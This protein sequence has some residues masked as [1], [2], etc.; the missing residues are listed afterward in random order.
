M[1]TLVQFPG[2]GLSFQINRIAF[3]IGSLNVYWYGVILATGLF[4]GVMFAFRHCTEFGIESDR[5][6]D[7]ILVG[8]VMAIVCARAYY[9]LMSPYEYDNIWQMLDVRRGGIAIYGAIAGAF[10]FGGLACKWR[11]IPLLPMFDLV[12][13]GFLI[14]QG[15]GR[16]GNFVNQEAFGYNTTLPWGMYSQA[17]HDYLQ[18]NVVTLPAGMTADPSL[19]VYPTFLYESIW[20]LAGFVLLYFYFK[21][22]KFHGDLALRYA[23]W[24]G[25]GRFWI[26]GL[27]TDS[28]LLV[29][30]LNLRASQLVAAV[31]VAA[32]LVLLVVLTR[33]AKQKQPLMVDLAI[34]SEALKAMQAPDGPIGVILSDKVSKLPASADRQAFEKAT[35]EYNQELIRVLNR[36]QKKEG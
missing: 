29:P 27:R 15:V 11:K 24:Y 16:W 13:M 17:T 18:S 19:P 10:V 32:A 21:K 22:R 20:C 3:S 9:V 4:L 1:S 2:L 6:I 36:T 7:V 34:G 23:V 26:E 31:T 14:G 25:L 8:T 12:S 5:M 28:L 30:S 35:E 33:R